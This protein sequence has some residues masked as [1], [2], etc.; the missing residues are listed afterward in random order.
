MHPSGLQASVLKRLIDESN[1]QGAVHLEEKE[2]QGGWASQGVLKRRRPILSEPKRTIGQRQIAKWTWGKH[3]R[4]YAKGEFIGCSGRT[5]S[6]T[7]LERFNAES[8]YQGAVHL[9]AKRTAYSGRASNY[10]INMFAGPVPVRTRVQPGRF[11]N[12]CRQKFAQ[13][14]AK[15]IIVVSRYRS[16]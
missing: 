11:S 2:P 15:N 16:Y 3:V 10:H 9:E 4:T 5:P 6:V 13:L 12:F 14:E 8:I 1:Y 7:V